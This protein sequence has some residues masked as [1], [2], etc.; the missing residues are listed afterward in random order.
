MDQLTTTVKI[1][2]I[3][4]DVNASKYFD[5]YSEKEVDVSTVCV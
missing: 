2:F 1:A 3:V 5:Q 4:S